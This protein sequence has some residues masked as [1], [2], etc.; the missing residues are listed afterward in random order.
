MKKDVPFRDTV[1]DW[2]TGFFPSGGR[3]KIQDCTP[4]RMGSG[5][6]GKVCDEVMHP[7]RSRTSADR[8]AARRLLNRHYTNNPEQQSTGE[9]EFP[10]VQK[11]G[12][13]KRHA[14][15]CRS[16]SDLPET[17]FGD[18]CHSRNLAN[19]VRTRRGLRDNFRSQLPAWVAVQQPMSRTPNR[20][21]TDRFLAAT[22]QLLDLIPVTSDDN[23]LGLG[24]IR[25]LKN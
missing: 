7:Q 17:G 3:S 14:A 18:M 10:I 5:K 8:L 1:R 16:R 19:N 6:S 11:S 15:E 13:R 4:S 24:I 9:S 20:N 21:P 22:A 12:S 23:F 2:D 25:T